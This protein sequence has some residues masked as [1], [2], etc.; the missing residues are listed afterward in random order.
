MRLPHPYFCIVAEVFGFRVATLLWML[1]LGPAYWTASN[2]VASGPLPGDASVDFAV[3]HKQTNKHTMTDQNQNRG[4][5]IFTH[6][7][8]AT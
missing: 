1:S 8:S 3:E 7:Y 4:E 6:C 5:P 2:A